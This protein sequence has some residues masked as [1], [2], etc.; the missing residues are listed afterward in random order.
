M[1]ERSSNSC[2][3]NHQWNNSE[4]PWAPS[5]VILVHEEVGI[6]WVILLGTASCRWYFLFL[7]FV[8]LFTVN[9]TDCNLIVFW[10]VLIQPRSKAI[11][12]TFLGVFR[13]RRKFWGLGQKW[14]CLMTHTMLL[15]STQFILQTLD[16]R[17]LTSQLLHW[18]IETLAQSTTCTPAENDLRQ[19]IVSDCS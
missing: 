17:C 18:S 1:E 15:F 12:G 9:N 19:A 5:R 3:L 16:N 4:E 2:N 7:F 14:K 11:R 13:S 10:R 8:Y 6:S